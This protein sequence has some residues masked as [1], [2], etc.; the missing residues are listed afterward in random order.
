MRERVKQFESDRAGREEL[1]RATRKGQHH[2]LLANT[3]TFPC[4]LCPRVFLARSGLV[5]H[6]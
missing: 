4:E 1:K 6:T 5:L 2:P 3:T